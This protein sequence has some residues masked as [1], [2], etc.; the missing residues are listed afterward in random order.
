MKPNLIEFKIKCF[1]QTFDS[2]H[3]ESVSMVQLMAGIQNQ[4]VDQN[5]S[6][7]RVFKYKNR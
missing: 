5:L 7:G 6:W 4:I 2:I 1:G 3:S